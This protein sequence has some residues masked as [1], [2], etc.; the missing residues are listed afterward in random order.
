MTA[1]D[2]LPLFDR[3]GHPRV[4]V[5]VSAG[6]SAKFKFDSKLGAFLFE[7][8]L[9]LGLAYPNDWGFF[10]STLADD[11]DPLDA[12]VWHPTASPQ[13]SV[14]V[15]RPV[16]LARVTQV[17][18][19]ESGETRNDRVIAVPLE[20]DGTST[21]A[22]RTREEL[23]C[24]LERVAAGAGHEARVEGWGDAREASAAIHEAARRFEARP[25]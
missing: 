21:L 20:W 22:A 10:P 18:T 1:L 3:R 16:A 6:S 4:V 7:R 17:Q 25:K 12:L 23:A 5:E 13:G 15:V 2:E 8:A 14:I 19:G 11:G 24:F 9:E